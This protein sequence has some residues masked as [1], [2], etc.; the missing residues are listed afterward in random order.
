MFVR[1]NLVGDLCT[2]GEDTSQIEVEFLLFIAEANLVLRHLLADEAEHGAQALSAGDW[3][4]ARPA[5]VT[6]AL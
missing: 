2:P 6:L 4:E 5:T 1:E 3:P